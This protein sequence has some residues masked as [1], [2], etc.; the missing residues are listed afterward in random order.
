MKTGITGQQAK[1]KLKQFGYNE[2]SAPKRKDLFALIKEI[3]SEP[4]F[5]LLIASGSLYMI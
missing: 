4:M 3:A 5:L 2:L 1:E